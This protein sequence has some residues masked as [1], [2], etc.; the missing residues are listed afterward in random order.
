MKRHVYSEAFA[1]D[2]CRLIADGHSRHSVH[3]RPDMPNRSSITR[4]RRRHPEF[5]RL[6]LDACRTRA[7]RAAEAGVRDP[8]CGGAHD[9]YTRAAGDEICAL[10]AQ[11]WSLTAIGRRPD[12]P[13]LCTI[14]KWK[15]EH[16]EFRQG[17]LAAFEQHAQLTLED[18]VEIADQAL[19]AGW[20]APAGRPPVT[21]REALM[22]ARLKIDARIGRLGRAAPR[23]SRN[24]PAADKREL[25][26]EE[27]LDLLE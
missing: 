9:S 24:T 1:R 20:A 27:W 4:W 8:G 18:C 23:S 15:A 13:S 16:E 19:G 26:H 17:Y 21:A 7:A 22:H 5:D 25:T 11:G 3:R 10:V 2:F 12:T 14:Y 6:Y